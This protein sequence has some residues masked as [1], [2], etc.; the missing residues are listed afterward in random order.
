MTA[1]VFGLDLIRP[2]QRPDLVKAAQRGSQEAIT[3]LTVIEET[4]ERIRLPLLCVSCPA[5]IC[6]FEGVTFGVLRQLAV[7]GAPKN[8]I[9]FIVCSECG[10]GDPRLIAAALRRDS[11]GA[12]VIKVTHP[13]GG[14]A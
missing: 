14:S 2:E 1:G 11:P 7:D 10:T 8:G 13:E 6:R 3:L 5:T 12:R 4:K 9:G